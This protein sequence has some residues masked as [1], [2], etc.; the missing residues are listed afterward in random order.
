[1]RNYCGQLKYKTFWNSLITIVLVLRAK[2]SPHILYPPHG[3]YYFKVFPRNSF[4]DPANVDKYI[5]IQSTI[6]WHDWE[7]ES[8]VDVNLLFSRRRIHSWL[9]QL[10]QPSKL[11]FLFQSWN[12]GWAQ[13]YR[14]NALAYS[15]LSL[16]TAPTLQ[17]RRTSPGSA[18]YIA[19]EPWRLLPG[20]K[21]WTL[22]EAMD[23]WWYRNVQAVKT[24]WKWGNNNKKMEH[25]AYT[26][27]LQF[28]QGWH[29]LKGRSQWMQ[30]QISEIYPVEIQFLSATWTLWNRDELCNGWD[31][32]ICKCFQ[33]LV[34][35]LYWRVLQIAMFACSS[36][37]RCT[38]V[39]T[40]S[41]TIRGI[42]KN[43][44]MTGTL[45]GK[46]NLILPADYCEVSTPVSIQ[47]HRDTRV[48][49]FL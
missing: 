25:V 49:G 46:P 21:H 15:T 29:P 42:R 10:M 23:A 3:L 4:L 13:I 28:F 17:S 5:H 32:L 43:N 6:A 40:T 47:R 7:A 11:I 1:M 20:A 14:R 27:P 24:I 38:L 30:H 8:H 2:R 41:K 26:F 39:L 9:I 34:G 44:I 16:L 48:Q 18:D 45:L 33:H 35:I 19:L 22:P 12:S 37:Q 36:H 31:M